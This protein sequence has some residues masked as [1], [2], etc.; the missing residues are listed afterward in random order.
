MTAMVHRAAS[1]GLLIL[2]SM[3]F[4]ALSIAYIRPW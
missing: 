3:P 4:L 1:Y 2:A